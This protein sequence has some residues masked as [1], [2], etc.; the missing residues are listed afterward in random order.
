MASVDLTP[1]RQGHS[2]RSSLTASPHKQIIL[3]GL[4]LV[5]AT[6]AV[7]HP[8]HAQPFAN[9]DDADYVFD[10][11]HVRSGLNWNTIHWAFVTQDAA[12]WHPVTWLSHALD[13]QIFGIDP[14]GPHDV[15]VFFHVLNALLLFWVLQ[16]ATGFIGRS[17]MVAALFALHPINVESVV[18]IAER[19][20]LLSMFFLLLTLAAYR[21]YAREP[22][23]SRY[24]VVAALSLW[25]SCPSPR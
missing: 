10:N 19:K 17:W 9:F 11:F 3:L 22:R 21:W 6:I 1:A 23:D 4:L 12:N 18:W 8:V 2:P 14:A 25:D 16:R 13:S 5:I 7:Y 24:V 15:N 20:N